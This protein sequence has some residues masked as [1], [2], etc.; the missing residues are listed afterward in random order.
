MK[1][2]KVVLVVV[3][4]AAAGTLLALA[5]K[6]YVKKVKNVTPDIDAEPL[7]L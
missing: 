7:G 6:Q 2:G 5:Y 3:A 1:K 4:I